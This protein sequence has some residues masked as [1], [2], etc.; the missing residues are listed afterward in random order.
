M[1]APASMTLLVPAYD[2]GML[3]RILTASRAKVRMAVIMNVDNGPGGR[4]TAYVRQRYD[5]AARAMRDRENVSVLGYVDCHAGKGYSLNDGPRRM[6]T[7]QEMLLEK[8][9]WINRYGIT[10]FFYDDAVDFEGKK[11]LPILKQVGLENWDMANPGSGKPVGKFHSITWEKNG[12]PAGKH[13]GAICKSMEAIP[14]KLPQGCRYFFCTDQNNYQE[15]P[16]YW[17]E[18]CELFKP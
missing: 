17:E 8:E 9:Q 4:G 7:A 15:L 16:S 6:K 3:G 13:A 11:V 14:G 2:A 1:K 10:R 18:L 5:W 12:I